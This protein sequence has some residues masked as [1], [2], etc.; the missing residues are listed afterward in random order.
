MRQGLPAIRCRLARSVAETK[1]QTVHQLG[2]S[3]LVDGA[4][5]SA[6]ASRSAG[7][8]L[9]EKF[10]VSPLPCSTAHSNNFE[11]LSPLSPTMLMFSMRTFTCCNGFTSGRQPLPMRS[12]NS[13]RS[14]TSARGGSPSKT[15]ALATV[16]PIVGSTNLLFVGH[17]FPAMTCTTKG[18]PP[19][20]VSVLCG[21]PP[22][23]TPLRHS[24][25][26]D[27]FQLPTAAGVH[28]ISHRP[29]SLRYRT[30]N[31][32]FDE[33]AGE[34]VSE[35][36]KLWLDLLDIRAQSFSASR[37]RTRSRSTSATALWPLVT[38]G[39]PMHVARS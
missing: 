22:R 3:A 1:K 6:E 32:V 7:S 28:L 30:C 15:I 33:V 25:A 5:T 24:N 23:A 37:C 9:S 2:S 29:G 14:A 19:I 8:A 20:G 17:G 4:E 34:D 10:S 13:M 36:F 31:G 12:H 26:T 18:D 16:V 35:P 21:R 11:G 38:S 39:R 27:N